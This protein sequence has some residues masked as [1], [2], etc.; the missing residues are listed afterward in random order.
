MRE[1]W[2]LRG[3][4]FA[5]ITLAAIYFNRIGILWWY[6]VPGVIMPLIDAGYGE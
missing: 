6:I 3:L 1:C 2:L 4:M 5:G